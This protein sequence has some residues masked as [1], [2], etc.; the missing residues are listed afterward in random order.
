M[1]GKVIGE[2]SSDVALRTIIAHQTNTTSSLFINTSG[3][4]FLPSPESGTMTSIK[5]FGYLKKE[6]LRMQLNSSIGL[7]VERLP[8]TLNVV[9][10]LYVLGYRLNVNTNVYSRFYG[11]VRITHEFIPNITYFDVPVQEGDLIGVL[12]PRECTAMSDGVDF[13]P[14]QVN[15]PTTDSQCSSAFFHPMDDVD[16]M[17]EDI[18]A[19]EFREEFVD[20]SME[21]TIA[22]PTPGI[23]CYTLP[24]C[25][26]P[27]LVCRVKC[28]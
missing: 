2:V 8:A 24:L 23:V 16:D 9:P 14:S 21:V 22:A 11:P 15:L 20:L 6:D 4:Y 28:T 18:E 3:S 12:I 26:G 27:N 17:L 10:Y 13:C 7:P 25:I 19:S 5:I 1:Q